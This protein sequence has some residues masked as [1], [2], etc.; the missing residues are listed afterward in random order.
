MADKAD[1]FI[2]YPEVEQRTDLSR[3]TIWRRSR[4]DPDF[5]QPISLGGRTVFSE[6]ALV[7]WMANMVKAHQRRTSTSDAGEVQ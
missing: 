5:P 1:K 3:V 2:S 7:R 6:A 4:S